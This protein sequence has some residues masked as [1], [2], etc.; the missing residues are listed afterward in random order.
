[1]KVEIQHKQGDF[2]LD[3]SFLG[4]QSG[5]TALYGPS[6]S[7]KSS[8]IQIVA[9]LRK[10]DRGYIRLNSVC[11][12][13]SEEKIN[14]PPEKRRIGYVFQDSRL[15][16]H[17][18]VYSNLNYGRKLVPQESHF[19][20]FDPVVDLLGIGHLLKRRPA[21][22]SGGEKQRVAIGRALL[23]SPS[24]LLMDEPLTSL[25]A[26]RKRE[27]LP[28]IRQICDTF[29]VPILYVSHSPAEIREI[30]DD[31]VVLQ[32]GRVAEFGMVDEVSYA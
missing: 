5:I 19:I 1:M 2:N 22:L 10:P 14:L 24:I 11:L 4:V 32:N 16:P 13:S 8:V 27:L 20:E 12:F 30:A 18:S 25:D 17:Y 6:G 7:G 29:K 21:D 9:G 15:L 28:F 3:V 23:M 31:V 26:A